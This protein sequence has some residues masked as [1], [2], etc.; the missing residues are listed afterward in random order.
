MD[1]SLRANLINGLANEFSS[2]LSSDDMRIDTSNYIADTGAMDCTAKGL[3]VD[4]LN[5]TKRVIEM[6]EKKIAGQAS[7]ADNTQYLLHLRVAKKCVEEII[8]QNMKLK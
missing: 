3:D 8:A 2:A 6:Q 5:K 1:D 7:S 4:T